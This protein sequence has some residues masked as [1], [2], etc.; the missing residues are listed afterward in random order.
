MI[1]EKSLREVIVHDVYSR[2]ESFR[3]GKKQSGAG[4]VYYI[5][6]GKQM[7]LSEYTDYCIKMELKK[8][9]IKK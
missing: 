2:L 3:Y 7:I 4:Y 9:G 5:V 1:T 8:F 6:N